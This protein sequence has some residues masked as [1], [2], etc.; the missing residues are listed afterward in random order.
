MYNIS[1]FFVVVGS[2]VDSCGDAGVI[3]KK[4]ADSCDG[5]RKKEKKNIRCTST[6]RFPR[7]MAGR[8]ESMRGAEAE[9][10]ACV[11]RKT[12]KNAAPAISAKEIISW[13]NGP[14]SS[15]VGPGPRESLPTVP[16]I[17]WLI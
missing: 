8:N 10:R 11:V 2:L 6:V 9:R 5:L 17:V 15:T 12:V 7:E 1:Y 16:T 13:N 3:T 4:G 14:E